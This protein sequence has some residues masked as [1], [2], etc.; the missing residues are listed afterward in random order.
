M[1]NRTASDPRVCDKFVLK[2]VGDVCKEHDKMWEFEQVVNFSRNVF[3][4][5][6]GK[7]RSMSQRISA[8]QRRKS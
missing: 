5:G 2:K 6:D 4:E 8:P 3:F 7:Q 1:V